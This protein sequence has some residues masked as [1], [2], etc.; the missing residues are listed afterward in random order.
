MAKKKVSNANHQKPSQKQDETVKSL[1]MDSSPPSSVDS[2]KLESLKSLNQMLLKE[3]VK[4]RQQVDSL[5]QSKGSLEMELTRSNS[6]KEALGSELAQLVERV[7]ELELERRV[8]AVYVAVQ[9][10]V[11]GEKIVR[12]MKGL[13]MEIREK[14]REVEERGSTIAR[15]N[16]ALSESEGA[17]G[18][19]R[20]ASKR[21]RV[22]RDVF[23]AKLNRQIEEDLGLRANLAE[24]S[25]KIRDF[26]REIEESRTAYNAVVSEREGMETRIKLLIEE[27]ESSV[28]D[29]K[30]SNKLLEKLKDDISV[31]VREKEEVEK[32]KNGEIG[33]RREL[34][35]VVTG[36]NEMVAGLKKEEAK[37]LKMVAELDKKCAEGETKLSEMWKE[38]DRLVGETKLSEKRIKE[39]AGEK[40]V[41]EKEL[42]DARK[43]LTERSL[44]L[45]GLANEKIVILEEKS[46]VEG[47][48]R[49][50]G[51]HVDEL[52]TAI[53][54]LE[55]SN[56]AYVDKIRNLESQVGEYK[57]KLKKVYVE[58]EGVE[59]CLDEEKQNA[60][61]LK[62]KIEE[63]EKRIQE[64]HKGS[65]EVK[66]E[67]AA[68]LSE[69]VELE[70]QCGMLREEIAS[71]HE[72]MAKSQA[73]FKSMK[74]KAETADANL[75]LVLKMLKGISAFCS[76]EVCEGEAGNVHANGE[77]LKVHIVEMETIKNAFKSK[78]AKVEEMNRQLK[79]L[80]SSVLD[81][82]KKK[83]FWTMLSSATTLLA[84]LSLAY[85]FRGH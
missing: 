62:A 34:E 64:S 85:V 57:S 53:V 80:R 21:V 47:R 39:L 78:A 15:L 29:L 27:K 75:K 36:I 81:E 31:I 23:E 37:L 43:N 61:K 25:E 26:E 20:A 5:L 74:S 3:A 38:T 14:E 72:T 41:I 11:E 77:G 13:E 67:K 70:S 32:E 79:A 48:V 17:L 28:R 66:T 30:E 73:E 82:Q 49:E 1:S 56:V 4:R 65:K 18:V 68:I 10:G 35:N 59:R 24:L 16:A 71:L 46:S 6:D 8:V 22:E 42:N 2:E 50:L 9:V 60:L 44:E 7:E 58:R 40:G 33:K 84:A 55:G 52:R 83:S 51:S 69:R 63:M 76:K 12:E 45:E 54:E 19:E